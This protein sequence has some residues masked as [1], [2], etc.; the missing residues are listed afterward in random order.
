MNP[1]TSCPLEG[2]VVSIFLFLAVS[3]CER[4][5]ETPAAA[6][7]S[8]PSTPSV[9]KPFRIVFKSYDGNP[10]TDKIEKFSFQINTLDLRQPS[11][12]LKLG[13]TVP[14]TLLKLK[15]FSFKERWN[16]EIKDKV[17]VSELTLQNSKTGKTTVLVFNQPTD[18]WAIFSPVPNAEK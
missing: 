8:V 3:A 1:L 2:I 10:K 17:D 14:N 7:P 4:H 12:F 9:H 6:T 15:Q 18:V 13:E 11:D 5:S 16:E